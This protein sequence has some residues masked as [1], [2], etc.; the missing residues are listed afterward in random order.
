MKEKVLH[1]TSI[2]YWTNS[3]KV[4]C[5]I[6][7]IHPAFGDHTCFDTQ[8]NYFKDYKVITLDLIGHGLSIG[9]GKLE[10]TAEYIKRIMEIEQLNKA[11]LVGV[12]IGAVLAQDFANKYPDLVS[13]LTSIGGYDI[14]NFTKE[15]QK[16]TGSNQKKMMFKAMFSIKAFAEDNKKISA[17]TKEAQEKFYQ[18]NLRFKKSSFRYLASLGKMINKYK[19]QDRAYPLLI[20]LGKY[21]NDKAKKAALLWH[22]S[23]PKSEFIV[24]EGAGHIV[25]MDTP[26]EF[27]KVLKNF[28]ERCS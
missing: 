7:F 11:N 9:K 3:S 23:E 15:L 2:H 1:N 24:F 25:N 14:N 13:S 5:A 20:G 22:E 27:N 6:V 16:D 12:S 4:D 17:Y 28:I 10:D 8:L 26:E 19:T 18:M 21:D